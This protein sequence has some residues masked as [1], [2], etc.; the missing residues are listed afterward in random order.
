MTRN[1][2]VCLRRGFQGIL[3]LIL[4]LLVL[5]VLVF[6]MSRLAPGDPLV[7]YY[8]SGVERMSTVEKEE[9]RERLG[10][11]DSIA[12]QYGVWVK[13]A[14]SGDLGISF[15]Y[16]VPV[17]AI[18][19]QMVPNTLLLGG[20]GFSLT[21][22]LALPLGAFLAL[23]E[24]SLP[25]RI[26]TRLGI[27]TGS[28]PVFWIALLLILMFSVFLQVLPASGAAPFGD[29]H[30]FS[31]RLP[32][33]ILPLT[34]MLLSHL[35]YYGYLARNLYLTEMGKEYMLLHRIKGMRRGRILLQH[36]TSN[37]L[38]AYVT[39]MVNS[40]PHLLGATYVI[41]EVFSYKGLGSLAFESAK[42]HDYNLLLV[43]A[44]LTGALVVILNR[45]E[46]ALRGI[47]QPGLTAE[48]S[49]HGRTEII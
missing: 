11:N 24:G 3:N 13:K 19:R 29:S 44:L 21:V 12:V 6:S 23:K 26:I 30:S 1:R 34:T 20:L 31:S 28:I 5:S 14:A 4:T 8:G 41:E 39:L 37:L 2:I 47:L 42:Y 15:K 38:P 40:V 22:L 18:L 49:K 7:A 25:D 10:L 17:T 32:Y 36:G 43:I 33:L 48:R 16:K 46:E 27:F 9:A 35:W 45:L